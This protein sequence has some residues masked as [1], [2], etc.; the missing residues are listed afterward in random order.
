MFRSLAR[1]T[2]VIARQQQVRTLA[3]PVNSV[4]R[5]FRMHVADEAAAEQADKIVAEARG[6]LEESKL[7]GYVK[8]VRTVCKAEYAYELAVVFDT[9]ENFGAYMAA[10]ERSAGVGA[11]IPPLMDKATALATD[12]DAVYV[13]NRVYDEQGRTTKGR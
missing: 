11:L 4:A 6:V 13:G 3:I 9:H 1:P 2:T 10:L 12:M 5:V 8:T 7:Q